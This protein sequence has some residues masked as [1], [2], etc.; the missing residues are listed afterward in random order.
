[1]TRKPTTTI[2]I[3]TEQASQLRDIAAARDLT[4]QSLLS[5]YIKTEIEAGTIPDGVP[6]YQIESKGSGISFAVDGINLMLTRAEADDI[7]NCL[8]DVAFHDGTFGFPDLTAKD[9]LEI[10]RR[11]R[12]LI[13]LIYQ[14]NPRAKTRRT[15]SP[16]VAGE[17]ARLLRKAAKKKAGR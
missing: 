16:N 4:V 7:A 15:L 11:G 9:I 10:R 12:G 2:S 17:L 5:H 3:S 14:R 8:D 1:V 13:L 6:D